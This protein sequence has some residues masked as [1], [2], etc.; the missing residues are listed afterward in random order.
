MICCPKY[1][2]KM[3][4]AKDYYVHYAYCPRCAEKFGHNYMSIFALQ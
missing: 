3:G 1:I 4:P 2:T